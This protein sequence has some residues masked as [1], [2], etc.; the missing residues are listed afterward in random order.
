VREL[1]AEPSVVFDMDGV[2]VDSEP[3][4]VRARKDLVRKANG[5]WIPEAETAMMG[6]SSDRWSAYMRD[7]LALDMTAEQIR[8]EVID[9]MIELYR[10]SVPLIPGAREAIETVGQRW[11]VGVASGSDRVLLDTVLKS[12][13]LEDHFAATV[14]AEDVA[15]GKPSPLIYQEAC[16]R[17][18]ARPASCVAIEDSGSGIASALAAGMKVIA[19]PRPGFEP[20]AEILSRATVAIPD[21]TELHPDLVARVLSAP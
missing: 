17:L 10:A 9:R 15:E 13:R 20:R 21:L 7:H 19:V 18:G 8:E 5:R 2:I 11:R 4:W 12:S 14:S 16:R 6:I 1:P 3:L